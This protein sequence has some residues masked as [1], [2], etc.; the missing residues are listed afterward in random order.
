MS[1][2]ASVITL[3]IVVI[4]YSIWKRS[5]QVSVKRARAYLQDGALVIDVRTAAEFNAGHLPNAMNYPLDG[6]EAVLPRHVRNKNEVLLLHCQSGMRSGLAKTKLTSLGYANV[7][8]L[9]SYARAVRIVASASSLPASTSSI[10][11]WRRLS[12]RSLRKEADG[13]YTR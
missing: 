7:F 13:A 8:N 2:T 5:N 4:I 3:G 1:T 11:C 9:G 6:I 12:A 10:L